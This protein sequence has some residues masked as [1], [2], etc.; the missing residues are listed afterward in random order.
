MGSAGPGD[1]QSADWQPTAS[2]STHMFSCRPGG[3]LGLRL[4]NRLK[5][6]RYV[7]TRVNP[8][9]GSPAF[10]RDH[11]RDTADLH[12]LSFGL[13]SCK[14]V[15]RCMMPTWGVYLRGSDNPRIR[16]PL[17]GSMVAVTL[18][19]RIKNTKL[20]GYEKEKATNPLLPPVLLFLFPPKLPTSPPLPNQFPSPPQTN[21]NMGHPQI[22]QISGHFTR[23]RFRRSDRPQPFQDR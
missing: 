9:G 5:S 13:G 18:R 21:L 19:R 22:Q 1:C 11:A 6:P 15:S 20:H 16:V 12:E 3:R 10:C 4:L 14:G 2:C 23:K 7:A 17:L 8:H